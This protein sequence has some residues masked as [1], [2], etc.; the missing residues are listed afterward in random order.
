L[1]YD[2]LNS[3]PLNKE[4]AIELVAAM[5]PYLEWQTGREISHV[6]PQHAD[7]VTDSAY[8]KDP[9]ADYFY[10]SHDIFAYLASVGTNLQNDVYAN[11]YEFQEDL[12]QVFARAHDGHFVFYPDA[13]T[14]ALQWGRKRS[15]VSISEDGSSLPV[16]KLYGEF[17]PAPESECTDLDRGCGLF[18][19]N[20]VDC[21]FD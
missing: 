21:L 13:L 9:P 11:E 4:A 18:P 3:V 1:A 20:S 19:I 8:L 5:E 2:C 6:T 15:L 17:S 10:P 12:Y 16:I 7:I 14:K